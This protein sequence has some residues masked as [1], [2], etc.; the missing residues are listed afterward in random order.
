MKLTGFDTV[1]KKFPNGLSFFLSEN[2]SQLSGGQKQVLALTRVLISEPKVLL[3][4][5]PTSAMDPRHE[6]LFI[7]QI[8]RYV[9]DKSLIVVTHRKPILSLTERLILVENGEI[10]LDGPRDEI[11][12]KLQ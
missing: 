11:L 1:L 9:Q 7:A 6:Q 12:R 4:D 3:L 5:E 8:K 2:G 10:K